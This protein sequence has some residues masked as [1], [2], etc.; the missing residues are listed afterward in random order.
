M[1]FSWLW[2]LGI[3]SIGD[4]GPALVGLN[5]QPAGL[6]KLFQVQNDWKTGGCYAMN[7]NIRVE[8]GK[9][10]QGDINFLRTQYL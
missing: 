3:R 10:P 5:F 7:P 6:P 1:F 8:D 9:L 4:T 2:D